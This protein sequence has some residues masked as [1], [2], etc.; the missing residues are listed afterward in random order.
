LL[1]G[2]RSWSAGPGCDTTPS[3]VSTPT[4]TGSGGST[5]RWTPSSRP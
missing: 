2:G 1:I 4:F 5:R 3:T